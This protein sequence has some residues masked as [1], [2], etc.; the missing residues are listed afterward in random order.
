MDWL[1]FLEDH[2][3]EYVTRGPNTK[4]GEASIK[5]PFCKDDD[6]SQHMGINLTKE[7]WGCW[8]SADHGGRSPVRLIQAILHCSYNQAQ[9]VHGQY[10]RP[11]PDHFEASLA[12]LGGLTNAPQAKTAYAAAMPPEARQIAPTGLSAPFWHY[13]ANRGFDDVGAL[14]EAYGLQCAVTGRYAGRVLIPIVAQGAMVGLTGRA[15]TTLQHAPRYLSDS[16]A[17]KRHIYNEDVVNAGGELL[18]VTE[19]PFD[20]IKVDYYGQR[21]GASATCMFGVNFTA[22][23]TVILATAA[24]LWDRIVVL[25][26]TA[27][28]SEAMGLIS[29][30]DRTNVYLGQLPEGA[31]DPGEL[32]EEQIEKMVADWR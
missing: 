9:I 31:D 22:E 12:A 27:A 14:C 24:A 8:R 13:L 7:R 25:F 16:E 21:Y 29:Y 2:G 1:R 32:T 3:V 19:G 26:D 28:Q 4:K 15:I 30:I 11:D 5:C 20:A 10:N 6:P 23:Q 18:F 17:I